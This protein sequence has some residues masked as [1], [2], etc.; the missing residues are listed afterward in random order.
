[1]VLKENRTLETA[2]RILPFIADGLTLIVLF[3][4]INPFADRLAQISGL[5]ALILVLLY[6]LFCIGVYLIRK[7][8]PGDTILGRQPPA[9]LLDRRFRAFLAFLFGLLMVTTLAYQLGYFAAI[10]SARS[11]LDEGS[12][13]SLFVYM[14]GALLGFSMLYI[15]ILAFPVVEKLEEGSWKTITWTFCGLLFTNS[16]LVFSVAQARVI[17]S[18]INWGN[19]L[20]M[21]VASSIILAVSFAPPRILL[22]TKYPYKMG[23]LSFAILLIFCSWFVIN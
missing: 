14:P 3:K 16:L 5:N 12:S 15:F 18:E 11:A 7:L 6:I 20:L 13:S 2:P 22:Q 21:L 19:N 10:Q 9:Y 8:K 23:L 17:A 4:V 1:M